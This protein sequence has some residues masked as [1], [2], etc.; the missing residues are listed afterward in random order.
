MKHLARGLWLALLAVPLWSGA[1]ELPSR[2]Y[3]LPIDP[4]AQALQTPVLNA[5]KA[6]AEDALAD[7]GAPL[8]YAILHKASVSL[9]DR[10]KFAVGRWS[11]VDA[12]HDLWRTRIDA[13][14]AVSIDLALAPFHLPE[15]A[16][17]WL[18]DA[19]GRLVRGPYTAADNPK[20]GEFWTPYVPGDVAYLEV[21][22]PKARRDELQLG[23]KSVQQAYRSIES[24]ESPFAK[25]GSCNVD[26]ICPQG[27]NYRE[28]INAVARYSISGGLCTGQLMNNTAQDGK[29]LFSTA[30][31]CISSQAD[32]TSLVAYWKYESPTCRATG[33]TE[34][35]TPISTSGNSVVQTGGATLLA[36][37]Q[38]ADTTLVELN[39]A[40]PSA[41]NPFWL[42]WDR[43]T[44]VPSAAVSIHHPSGHEKRIS[45]E[46]DPLLNSDVAPAGVPGSKHWHVQGWDQGTTEQG[47]SGSVLMN[48]QKRLIGVLSGGAASCSFNFDD[49]YGRLNVAWEGGGTAASRVRDW[50]DP[51]STGATGIDG[52]STCAKPTV[53]LS[54]GTANPTT[55]AE[56][57][58]NAAISG[59]TGPY[60]LDWD[61]DADGLVDRHVTGVAG[62][63][64]LAPRYPSRRNTT[65]SLVVTDATGCVAST[66][67]LSL[68]VRGPQ[69]SAAPN[70]AATQACGDG[71]ANI[72]PGEIWNV[73]VRVSNTGED[74]M[75]DGLAVFSGGS[76][77]GTSSGGGGV[78]DGFGYR[79]LASASSS[80][81]RYQPV[82]MS[83][84]GSLVPTQGPHGSFPANDEG[85]VAGL[86]VGGAAPFRFYNSDLSTLMMSTNGYLST[87]VADGGDDYRPVCGIDNFQGVVDGRIQALHRDLAIQSGGSMKHRHFDSCPRAADAGAASQGCTVFE[88]RGMGNV[89]SGGGVSGNAVFQTIL[90]D[91][92]FEIVHQYISADPDSGA[93]AVIGQQSPDE[94]HRLNYKCSVSNAAPTGT[95]VCFFHPSALPADLAEAKVHIVSGAATLGDVATGGGQDVTVKA[96]IDPA[97]QCGARAAVSFLGGVD[98]YAY[99]FAP[100]KVL[101]VAMPASGNCQVATQ[102]A[103]QLQGFGTPP[104]GGVYF[105]T[106]RPGNGQ[107]IFSIGSTFSTAWFTAKPD[108]TPV[109]YLNVGPWNPNF[110]QATTDIRKFTRTSS[111][112]FAVTST[113]RGTAWYARGDDDSGYVNA[114]Y[115]D[116]VWGG[117][118][119]TRFYSTAD[120]PTPNHTGGWANANESGWGLVIDEHRVLGADSTG[121]LSYLYD[122][123]NEPRWTIADRPN[124]ETTQTHSVYSVHCPSCPYFPNLGTNPQVVGTI[125][126]SYQS[127]TTGT[128]DVNF[129][130]PASFGGT[131]NRTSFPLQLIT[132]PLSPSP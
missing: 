96:Y 67:E 27:D 80:S 35:G 12:E 77:P 100:S 113:S 64:L 17:V 59:G 125:S 31:H 50:L 13:P 110:S 11:T 32:A 83:A 106:A 18:S 36:T 82:D 75:N 132:P 14:G 44:T 10:S 40:V 109:W 72:E 98:D 25:S 7:K 128:F 37:Y 33:S 56:I 15:G 104:A 1:V 55:D 66:A 88:W 131:W 61:V 53:A 24:G 49:Y 117:E 102:C 8:R 94:V 39:T 105:N 22:V 73:P 112:P 79:A 84:A 19:A 111:A 130:W 126:R 87:N 41:A 124:T 120:L 129:T 4:G 122:G 51:G 23:I 65:V 57:T 95:S 47:S 85:F 21:L 118:K 86:A 97:A 54:L 70:G 108:R 58:I 9:A 30:N 6:L 5:E 116:G 34:S 89:A 78:S 28:Q 43:G 26:T 46:N 63:T 68:G 114:W 99:S 121:I 90:Y 103:A 101:D 71:D 91:Q 62:N 2:R 60:T 74:A 29:R 69:L 127:Q 92:S 48:P 42:G 3:Q 123:Q 52:K 16:E 38:P 107:N 119:Q 115:L 93:T 81:C 45:F 76:A 20:F